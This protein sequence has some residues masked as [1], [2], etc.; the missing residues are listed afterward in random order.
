MVLRADNWGMQYLIFSSLADW[1]YPKVD[2]NNS[3]AGHLGIQLA[4]CA[5]PEEDDPA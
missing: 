1:N 3:C 2:V 4:Q 5:S